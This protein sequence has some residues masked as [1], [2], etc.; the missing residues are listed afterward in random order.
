MACH[1][2][3]TKLTTKPFHK[4]SS[5]F[6][7]QRNWP[8][9]SVL[10]LRSLWQLVTD[11]LMKTL[12]SPFAG[13]QDR[14]GTIFSLLASVACGNP[15]L[16]SALVRQKSSLKNR[17]MKAR[18]AGLISK[19]VFDIY[20]PHILSLDVVL[21]KGLELASYNKEA[22]THILRYIVSHR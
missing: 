6:K 5:V 4:R 20:L 17:L 8:T 15:Q 21:N 1:Q 18:L 16:G 2:R 9:S 22:W 13:L 7:M 3:P 14:S 12:N 11:V 10:Y 19:P